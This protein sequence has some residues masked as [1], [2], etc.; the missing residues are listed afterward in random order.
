MAA[1]RAF[2]TATTILLLLA[3]GVPLS[4]PGQAELRAALA[5]AAVFFWSLF[6]PASMPAVAAFAIG[7]LADLLGQWPMGVGAVTLLVAHGAAA[8]MRRA[9]VR[10]GLPVVWLA[11]LATAAGVAG[12]AW[13]LASLLTLR[14]LPAAP[15]LFQA[16]LSAGLFPPLALLLTRAHRT[17]AEPERA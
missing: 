9:L 5:V 3:G 10:Q 8:R 17:V 7:L 12:L 4:V 6:R 1:R 2:P 13:G 15:A 16:A 11:F 14:L